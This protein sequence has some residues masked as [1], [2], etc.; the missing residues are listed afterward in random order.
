MRL[1]YFSAPLQA[2]KV[3]Y[4]VRLRDWFYDLW[5]NELLGLE[6]KGLLWWRVGRDNFNYLI[7][8]MVH[9]LVVN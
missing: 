5:R 3:I 4:Q 6:G 8:F 9:V 2:Q 1:H 7:F